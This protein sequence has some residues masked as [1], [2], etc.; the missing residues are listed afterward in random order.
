MILRNTTQ[1]L[2]IS[3]QSLNRIP[4]RAFRVPKR[5]GNN[6]IFFDKLRKK[7]IVNGRVT[8][9]WPTRFDIT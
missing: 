9:L 8:G 4:A 2:K 3:F 6:I 7:N 1:H 5:I